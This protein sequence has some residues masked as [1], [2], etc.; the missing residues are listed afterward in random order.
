MAKVSPAQRRAVARYNAQNY[1]R[2]ELRL[3][4]GRKRALEAFA[5]KHG[6]SINGCVNGLI[7]GAMGFTAAEWRSDG[8]DQQPAD[9]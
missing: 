6:Q 3:P 1:D 9:D 4:R 7:C 5:R 8:D 2:V